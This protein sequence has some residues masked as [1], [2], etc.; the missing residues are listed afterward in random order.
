MANLHLNA[1]EI[2][3]EEPNQKGVK[4][5]L[6]KEE[7]LIREVLSRGGLLIR[8]GVLIREEVLI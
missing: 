2:H 4:G 3:F 1:F 8:E 7:V 6:I 5:V